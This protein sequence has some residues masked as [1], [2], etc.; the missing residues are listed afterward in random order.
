VQPL[1][2]RKRLAWSLFM[3]EKYNISVAENR[4]VVSIELES[5]APRGRKIA[6]GLPWI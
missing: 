6:G 1:R 4:N 3:S 2:A 5:A